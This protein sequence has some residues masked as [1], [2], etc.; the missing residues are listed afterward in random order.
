VTSESYSA[1]L[2]NRSSPEFEV[3]ARRIKEAIESEYFTIPGEQTVNVLQFR[4]IYIYIYIYANKC[5][6]L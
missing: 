1:E 5:G 3:L 2:A 4:Y 6:R